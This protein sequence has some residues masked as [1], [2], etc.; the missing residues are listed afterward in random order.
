[1]SSIV[2]E[3][4][5]R[6]IKR[7][8]QNELTESVIYEKIA[9]FAKGEENQ[10]T[11][12]RLAREE[13]AHYEIWK[14]YSG[15]QMK[16]EQGKVLKYTLLARVLGFTFAVKLMERGEANAQIEYDVLAQEVAESVAI[17]QQEEEHEQA[18]LGV[19][20]PPGRIKSPSK[21]TTKYFLSTI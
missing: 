19:I 16:P 5:L 14:K 13:R 18:L 4:A 3:N 11:L 6:I 8:Q 20:I 7:M 15:I 9:K 1:M 12:L 17:R 21:D 10:A 2:S